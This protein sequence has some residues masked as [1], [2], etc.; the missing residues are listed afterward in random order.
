M[1]EKKPPLI[2]VIG[3]DGSGKSTVCEYLIEYVRRYGPA[4]R[5]HLGKQSGNVGRA[6][7]KLPVLGH[8][9]ERLIK[10]NKNKIKSSDSLPDVLPALV[11]ISFVLRRVLRFRHMLAC[12]K[13]GLIVLTDRFPQIQ[14]PNAY[15]GPVFPSCQKGHRFVKWLAK[16]E[17]AAF[18]WMA[19]HKPDLVIKLI[20]DL[21]VA[22]ARKPD[23]Q[24]TSLAKKIAVTPLLKFEG[25]QI[26]EIDANKPLEEVISLAKKAVS[27]FMESYGYRHTE[28]NEPA[29]H[30]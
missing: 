16:R 7:I 15:D 9:V 3:S 20:V 27:A 17:R 13:R 22:S 28:A 25:A 14:I 6:A 21:E 11:I 19:G 12:R 29:A 24:R 23:H 4:S 5:I 10:S 1:N 30:L 26:V 8:S 2:A 18:Q